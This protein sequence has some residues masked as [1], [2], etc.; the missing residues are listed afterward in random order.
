MV[1]QFIK[2]WLVVIIIIGVIA[3][4]DSNLIAAVLWMCVCTTGLLGFAAV[5]CYISVYF[6]HRRKIKESKY[7]YRC[8]CGHREI[9]HKEY[10]SHYRWPN[11]L[12]SYCGQHRIQEFIELPEEMR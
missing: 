10:T 7:R 6:T 2:L 4:G 3:T 5:C 11:P 12:C 9:D 8:P 1:E